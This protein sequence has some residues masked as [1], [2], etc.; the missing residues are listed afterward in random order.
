VKILDYYKKP[1]RRMVGMLVAY[2]LVV[3]FVLAVM[4]TLVMST[5]AVLPDLFCH[6]LWL[7]G[8]PGFLI[9]VLTMLLYPL[10]FF[11]PIRE[12]SLS[13]SFEAG[14]VALFLLLFV[15]IGMMA[16]FGDVIG[17][18]DEGEA[19]YRNGG[20][21]YESFASV[22]ELE[23]TELNPFLVPTGATDIRRCRKFRFRG[24]SYSVRC[25]VDANAFRDFARQFDYRFSSDGCG[26]FPIDDCIMQEL[27]ARLQ[28]EKKFLFCQTKWDRGDLFFA[29]DE[30]RQT[31][32]VH[33]DD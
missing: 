16:V 5:G 20:N 2:L 12:K 30:G 13:E 9:L 10:R 26:Y 8:G 17:M 22:D 14:F 3:I 23:P 32:Y 11:I 4:K 19:R 7:C 21:E 29:Y 18:I 6:V 33:Y 25:Q 28:S 31:L 1:E 15:I 27:Q 24:Q